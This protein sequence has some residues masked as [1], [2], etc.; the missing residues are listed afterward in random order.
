MAS[1]FLENHWRAVKYSAIVAGA[2]LILT[3][4]FSGC[5]ADRISK[6]KN[7]SQFK[8]YTLQE[9]IYSDLLKT[10][11]EF[12]TVCYDEKRREDLSKLIDLASNDTISAWDS[13][14]EEL[15]RQYTAEIRGG[16]FD[17][18]IDYSARLCAMGCLATALFGVTYPLTLLGDWA[19]TRR[20]KPTLAS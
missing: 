10:K 12:D 19:Y 16:I 14:P 6:V 3:M 13:C 15:K 2:G 9:K 5:E 20:K 1:K 18:G 11:S 8:Q 4:F 17:R 7:K